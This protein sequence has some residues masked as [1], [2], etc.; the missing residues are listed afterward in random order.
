VIYYD[1]YADIPIETVDAFVC[2][3]EMGRLVTVSAEGVPHIGLYPFTYQ[4]TSI[5]LHLNR[6]DEQLAD[7]KARSR[8]LFEV[9][10]VLAVIPSYWV[11][12]ENAVMATAYHRTVVFDCEA[13]VLEDAAGCWRMRPC[14]PISRCGF[15][16]AFSRRAG[17]A[18]SPPTT[19]CIVER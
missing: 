2:E 9:D 5:E 3:A 4:G 1:Y 12:P 13:G 11:H 7:L 19:P 10:E 8:C 6:A 17:F 14:W 16:L 15:S 18:Q